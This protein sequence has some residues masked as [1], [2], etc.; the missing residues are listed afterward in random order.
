MIPNIER[1]LVNNPLIPKYSVPKVCKKILCATN[2]ISTI[3]KFIT[4]ATTTFLIEL[5]ERILS[6]H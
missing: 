5:V 6:P 4:V 1:I 2:P 3:T